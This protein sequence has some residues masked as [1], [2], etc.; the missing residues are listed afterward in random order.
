VERLGSCALKI[1]CLPVGAAELKLGRQAMF[2]DSTF[3]ST[4]RI[5]TRSRGWM[6]AS[7]AFNGSILVALILIPLIYPEALPRM[8]TVFLM[9][10][11]K[12]PAPEPKPVARIERTN[13]VQPQMRNGKVFAP[14][15]IPRNPYIADTPEILPNVNVATMDDGSGPGANNPFG[16]RSQLPAVREQV[17]GPVRVSGMVVEGLLLRKTM[18]VYPA[19]ARATGTQGTVVLQATISRNGTIE[20]LRV[21]SGP[22]MLQQAAMDAVKSWRYRPYL[23]SGEPVEVETTVNVVFKLQE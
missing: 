13:L 14:S 17:R 18:P 10:V 3:E 23:L 2:E 19:I 22:A 4:G 9:E 20:N 21:A 6:I 15:T 1:S 16:D 7:C 5:R 12:T 11:P 8:A